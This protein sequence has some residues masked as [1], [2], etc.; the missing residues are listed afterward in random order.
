MAKKKTVPK[1]SAAKKSGTAPDLLT[2]TELVAL[3]K[4]RL[5]AEAWDFILGGA[6]TETTILRN[7]HSL[8]GIGGLRGPARFRQR[9]AQFVPAGIAQGLG[10]PREGSGIG[11]RDGGQ[12]AHR[13]RGGVIIVGGDEPADLCQPRRQRRQSAAKLIQRGRFRLRLNHETYVAYFAFLQHM[14]RA[15]RRLAEHRCCR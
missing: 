6:E 2:T 11:A 8:D 3:A 4:K 15:P 5:S 9:R 1:R 12:L 14:K 13:T 10:Q 7:R